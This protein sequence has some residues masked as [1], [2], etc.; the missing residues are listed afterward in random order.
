MITEIKKRMEIVE[1]K[2][3]ESGD[4][5]IRNRRAYQVSR[6]TEDGIVVIIDVITR[7]AWHLSGRV[8]VKTCY[9]LSYKRFEE[10]VLNKR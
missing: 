4:V 1:L 9:A 6:R 5:F 7:A 2:T 10:K 3:L 8:K